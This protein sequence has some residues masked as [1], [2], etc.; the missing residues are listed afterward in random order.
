M[1]TWGTSGADPALCGFGLFPS[2]HSKREEKSNLRRLERVKTPVGLL[3]SSCNCLKEWCTALPGCLGSLY[4]VWSHKCLQRMIHP[5][6]WGVFVLSNHIPF[7]FAVRAQSPC[8]P[9]C[10]CSNSC[11]SPSSIMSFKRNTGHC[12][13]DSLPQCL[14]GQS[15]SPVVADL[16]LSCT[17]AYLLSS[18][19]LPLAPHHKN[20]ADW[21]TLVPQWSK[22]RTLSFHDYLSTDHRERAYGSLRANTPLTDGEREVIPL[23]PK[24]ITS[25]PWT[26]ILAA[27]QHSLME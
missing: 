27:L 21:R 4:C 8:H 5:N 25:C 1:G 19:Y 20:T 18:Q 22:K 24:R 17:S 2:R 6:S 16:I 13:Q 23:L 9:R 26:A 7:Q 14:Q 3:S 11:W 15:P 12:W 10:P